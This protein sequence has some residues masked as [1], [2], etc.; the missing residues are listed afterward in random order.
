MAQ[1]DYIEKWL[2]GTL[3]EEE[4]RAFEQTEDY[5]NLVRLHEAVKSFSAPE[6]DAA[7]EYKRLKTK[8]E[9]QPRSNTISLH[10]PTLLLRIRYYFIYIT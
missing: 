8:I 7:A 5:Q 1:E 6:F 3:S 9:K 4:K 10:I 2:N